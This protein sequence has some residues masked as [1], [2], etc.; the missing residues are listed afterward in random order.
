MSPP[1]HLFAAW[2]DL[3][4]AAR[5]VEQIAFFTDF[6]GTLVPICPRPNQV[7]LP[8]RVR[9]LLA[10]IARKV[11]V[12]GVVSGRKLEDVRAK[13]GLRKIWYVGAHGF[14]LYH[15]D[16]RRILLLNL[17]ER[18][19]IARVHR[20]VRRRLRG[21]PGIEVEPKGA[22]IA[23]HY[24][25]ASPRS[26][27]LARAVV[28]QALAKEPGLRLVSGKKVWELMPD[29]GIDKWTAIQ[30]I[31]KHER[32]RSSSDRWL[33][34][35]FG[36]DATDERVFA[37]LRGISVAIGRRRRTRARFFLRSPAE[38]SRFLKRFDEIVP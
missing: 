37:R 23:V 36:D 29:S 10:T 22:T 14:S 30:I 8:R 17:R 26:Y 28:E 24:R 1:R 19:L 34:F 20:W 12:V 6:D 31:L 35:Y 3:T 7:R 25:A 9:E 4:D 21:L 38:V 5:K 11:A 27:L 32:K 16:N 33:V 2:D 18:V 15:P 13:V